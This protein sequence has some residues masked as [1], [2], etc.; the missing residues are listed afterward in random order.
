[1]GVNF[2][3]PLG[4]SIETGEISANA[5]S[6]VAFDTSTSDESTTATAYTDTTLSVTMTTDASDL[7]IIWSGCVQFNTNSNGQV[8]IDI[9]G[10]TE[11]VC[12]LQSDSTTELKNPAVVFKKTV[13]AG[14]H[15][16]KLKIKSGV[17]GN[18]IS[19]KGT[20]QTTT[21]TVIE[22]KR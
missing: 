10:T 15:T 22:L 12:H 19:L 2:G 14:S 3:N 1:M 7:I 18:S 16:I 17:A 5:V 13:T 21:L 6:Q 11:H 9:D 8:A 4:S 20:I